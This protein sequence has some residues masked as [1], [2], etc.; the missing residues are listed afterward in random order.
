M[1]DLN[2]NFS[3][4][5]QFIKYDDDSYHTLGCPTC[6]YGSE[7]VNEVKITTTHYQISIKFNQMYE[8]AFSEGDAIRLFA[9]DLRDMT[10]DEF[11]AHIDKHIHEDYEYSLETYEVIRRN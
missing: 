9:I 5:N 7:Y 6:N 2:I 4:G 3:D 8:Y 10:E 11:I 1:A